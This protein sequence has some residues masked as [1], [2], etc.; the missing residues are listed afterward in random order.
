MET[1]TLDTAINKYAGTV[2]NINEL[3]QLLREQEQ[4][5]YK[6]LRETIELFIAQKETVFMSEIQRIY[7][8]DY[9][10]APSSKEDKEFVCNKDT[11]NIEST[12]DDWTKEVLTIAN[13][14]VYKNEKYNK[15]FRSCEF[16][17]RHYTHVYKL[18]GNN[19]K[20]YFILGDQPSYITLGSGV[21]PMFTGIKKIK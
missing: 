18:E 21:Y 14:L 9:T 17:N 2:D 5:S 19:N 6:E 20:D 7:N 3:K 4:S 12:H 10:F 15:F 16:I 8:T 1:V 13:G 11:L